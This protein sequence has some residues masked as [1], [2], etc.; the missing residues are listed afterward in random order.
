MYH[1]PGCSLNIRRLQYQVTLSPAN[2]L[3]SPTFLLGI[4]LTHHSCVKLKTGPA[5]SPTLYFRHPHALLKHPCTWYHLSLLKFSCTMPWIF[6]WYLPNFLFHHSPLSNA[7]CLFIPTNEW[8]SLRLYFAFYAFRNWSVALVYC[9]LNDQIKLNPIL[10]VVVTPTGFVASVGAGVIMTGLF[11]HLRHFWAVFS[12]GFS[13]SSAFLWIFF[14]TIT[15]PEANDRN[16]PSHVV[17]GYL[18]CWLLV[19]PS[20]ICLAYSKI[21]QPREIFIFKIWN[22]YMK[23]FSASLWTTSNDVNRREFYWPKIGRIFIE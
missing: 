13:N 8:V 21:H 11:T 4:L 1:L 23:I 16:W 17:L 19:L 10:N 5:L 12:V 9:Y 3:P 7:W 22:K 14:C 15:W 6:E 18:P 20:L 2:F